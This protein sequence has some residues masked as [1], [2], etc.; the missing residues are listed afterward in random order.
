L[1]VATVA[2]AAAAVQTGV[3]LGPA[4]YATI[5]AGGD[6]LTDI[7]VTALVVVLARDG[8]LSAALAVDAVEQVGE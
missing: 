1:V 3:A 4:G 8:P 5:D 7:G 2:G 6:K